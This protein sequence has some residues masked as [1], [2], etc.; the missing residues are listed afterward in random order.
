MYVVVVPFSA[1]TWIVIW[2]T[3]SKLNV[4]GKVKSVKISAFSSSVV[5][6]ILISSVN[7]GTVMLYD[8]L[9]TPKLLTGTSVFAPFVTSVILI[10]LKFAFDDLALFTITVYDFSVKSSAVTFII[11]VWLLSD[12]AVVIVYF[13]SFPGVTVASASMIASKVY[14]VVPVG[15]SIV[16]DVSVF[17]NTQ[18]LEDVVSPSKYKLILDASAFADLVLVIFTW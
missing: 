8:T 5:A 3:E 6:S 7:A 11:L 13:V 4:F 1:L 17:A 10:E 16:Q 18:Y 14:P 9:S 2:F 12:A 15:T